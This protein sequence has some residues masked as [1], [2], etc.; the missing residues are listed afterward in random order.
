MSVGAPWVPMYVGDTSAG[1][2]LAFKLSSMLA[3][4]QTGHVAL[5]QASCLTKLIEGELRIDEQRVDELGAPA[6]AFDTDTYRADT[7]TG[8]HVWYRGEMVRE[9]VRDYE[10]RWRHL[11]HD[12]TGR[13]VI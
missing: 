13:I 10:W 7:V 4:Q 2:W 11:H 12:G 3:Q 5:Y 8:A 6:T 9:P 1:L